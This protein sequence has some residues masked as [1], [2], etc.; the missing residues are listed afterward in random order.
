MGAAPEQMKFEVEDE[1]LDRNHWVCAV[2]G[3]NIAYCGADVTYEPWDQSGGLTCVDCYLVD[4]R[5]P[6]GVCPVNGNNCECEETT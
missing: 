5:T 6:E 1:D 4:L 2:A 3:E